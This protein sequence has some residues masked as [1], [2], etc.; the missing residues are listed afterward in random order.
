MGLTGKQAGHS[1]DLQS[2]KVN[3]Q[4][5]RLPGFLCWNLG[6]LFGNLGF[7]VCRGMACRRQ[8]LATRLCRVHRTVATSCESL[9]TEGFLPSF[10]RSHPTP[11]KAAQGRAGRAGARPGQAR[12]G[13]ARPQARPGQARPGQARPG[14]VR[15]GRAGQGRAGQGRAG[16]GRGGAAGGGRGGQRGAAGGR[17]G[18]AAQGRAGQGRAGQGRGQGR[19]R[20]GSRGVFL[21]FASLRNSDE[22]C[23]SLCGC[24]GSVGRANQTEGQDL[25]DPSYYGKVKRKRQQRQKE[26]RKVRKES[27]SKE[28]REAKERDSAEAASSRGDSTNAS[29][30]EPMKPPHRAGMNDS[31]T[32]SRG[33]QQTTCPPPP[34]R[35]SPAERGLRRLDM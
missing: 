35:E 15:A 18:R 13:Q 19:A 17:G 22:W 30:I 27:P 1:L 26:R 2:A 23:P 33:F 5:N 20:Q 29:P 8:Y 32:K 24:S 3:F 14:Q 21:L 10:F 31:S 12:P 11:Y 6:F 4:V 16:Q 34:G 9:S 7:R 28:Q 25:S